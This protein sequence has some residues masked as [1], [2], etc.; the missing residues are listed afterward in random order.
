MYDTL[1]ETVEEEMYSMREDA[2]ATTE[3]HRKVCVH[4]SSV[5]VNAKHY[6]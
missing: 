6:V 5:L 1:R 4:V 2:L 3:K